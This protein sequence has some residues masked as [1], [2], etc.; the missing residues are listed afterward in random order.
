M[1]TADLRSA[2]LDFF[3]ERNHRVVASSSLVP[4]N[5][6]TMLFTNAGMVQFKDALLGREARDYSRAASCQRCVRAGGKHNDLEN[7]GYTARHHTLFEMLGNFSFGDYFKE[8]TISWAWQFVTE[9]LMLPRDQLWITVH[10]TDEEARAI[11]IGKIGLDESRVIDLE[12]NFWTMGETGPCGPDSEIFY[13]QGPEF[14]GGPPGS[15]DEDGDRF[16]EF[17]NLVFPQFDRAA[18]GSLSPL[19]TPGVDTGLG[20]ERAAALTQGVGSNYEID[21][22]HDVI[23]RAGE[24]AGLTDKETV[25]RDPSLRVIS[26][27]IRSAAF[28]IADGVIPGN[29]DRNYVLRRIIRRA[30]RHGNKLQIREPFFHLLVEPLVNSMGEAYPVLSEE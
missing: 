14:V 27:H 25:F 2:F 16:L 20:L 15:A 29:E 1:R 24:F 13:D 5:D 4:V 11:W 26:D 6:P 8:E 23:Q 17:W 19:A 18:D 7:V 10:P 3:G 21:L 22:F 30:L 28:L 12:D 9:V